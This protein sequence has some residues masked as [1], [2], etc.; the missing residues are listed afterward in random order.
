MAKNA[1]NDF[2]STN[3]LSQ[4]WGEMFSASK[5]RKRDGFGLDGVSLNDFKQNEDES[6]YRLSNDLRQSKYIPQLLNPHFIPKTNGKD[7]LICVPSVHDRLVQRALLSQLHDKGYGFVNNISYG[8]VKGRSVNMAATKA[9][10]H[11]EK[12]QWVYKADISSFFDEIDRDI[13]I[14]RVKK[15]VRLRSLHS[16]ME[17]VINTEVYCRHDGITRRIKKLGIKKGVGLRQG[18]PMSP[19]LSNLMLMEFDQ[20]IQA[21]GISMVRYADDFVAFAS[22]ESECEEIHELCVE[23]LAKEGLNIHSLNTSSKTV[24]ARPSEPIEFLGLELSH[25]SDGYKLKVSQNQCN[26]IKQKILQLSDLDYCIMQGVSISRLTRKLE[27]TISGYYGA[28]GLCSNLDQLT[29]VVESAKNL[30][31]SRLFVD[32]FGIDY[33]LLTEKQKKFLEIG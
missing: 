27:D 18:M 23:Q 6:I 24:I 2:S 14:G 1:F 28:Y 20:K 21:K 3:H 32:E 9:I 31:M 19:Y 5:K 25:T 30:A 4:A 17:S 7:R 8:F 16:I 29:D 11:R 26:S 33:K 13:L 12:K 22:S 10:E 15:K